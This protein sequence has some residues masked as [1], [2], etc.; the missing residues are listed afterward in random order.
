[1]FNENIYFMPVKCS[2]YHAAYKVVFLNW[3]VIH[4]SIMTDND[5]I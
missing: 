3:T 4:V 1:M 2:D 5:Q